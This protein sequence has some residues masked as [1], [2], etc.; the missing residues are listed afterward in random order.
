MLNSRRQSFMG[1]VSPRQRDR[2]AI[3]QS[4][5]ADSNSSARSPRRQSIAGRY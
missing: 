2:D 1:A 3:D 5:N 4:A